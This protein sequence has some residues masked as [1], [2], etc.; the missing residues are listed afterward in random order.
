MELKARKL[1]LLSVC[2]LNFAFRKKEIL[3]FKF[4]TQKLKCF[5]SE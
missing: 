1:F 4:E 2:I 5:N 3:I